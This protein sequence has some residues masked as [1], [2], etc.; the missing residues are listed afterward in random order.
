MS[1]PQPEAVLPG[2]RRRWFALAVVA[3]GMWLSV[4]NVT[5]VNIALPAIAH[6]MGVDVTSVG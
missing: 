1:D 2:A 5:I 6:D 4:L 3:A